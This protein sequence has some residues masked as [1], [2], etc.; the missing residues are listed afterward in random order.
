MAS[1][2]SILNPINWLCL[3]AFLIPMG[4]VQKQFG[5]MFSGIKI[6]MIVIIFLA[7]AYK[8]IKDKIFKQSLLTKYILFFILSFIPSFIFAY[9]FSEFLP[10]FISVLGYWALSIVI[11]NFVK[12]EDE[13][14][15]IVYSF[16]FSILL[17]SV[18]GMIQY[19]TG[20]TIIDV[21][22]RDSLYKW[23]SP[24]GTEET[25]YRLLGT[26]KNPSAFASHFVVAL[27]IIF[28]LLIVANGNMKRTSILSFFFLSLVVLILTF[29]RGA[30]LSAVISLF[31]IS[32]YNIKKKRFLITA[33]V[34]FFISTVLLYKYWP[35]GINYYM[36]PTAKGDLSLQERIWAIK[37]TILMFL[38]NPFGVGMGNYV[39]KIV[40]YGN[41]DIMPPHNIFAGIACELGLQG[42]IT[43]I[44]VI[45]LSFKFAIYGI[46]N[47]KNKE[48]KGLLIGLFGSLIGFQILGMSHS[49][50][51]NVALWLI[52]ALINAGYEIVKR[53]ASEGVSVE[54]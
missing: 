48:F 32:L 43:Y 11:L 52:I 14:R 20:S 26:E 15:K 38:N 28:S 5:L 39:N 36:F 18:F 3:L 16:L 10:V 25:R 46:K 51:I 37:P 4:E 23:D 22:G 24:T 41:P 54:K 6:V 31:I 21:S 45:A 42:L 33:A 17:V 29:S 7:V 12:H 30:I 40:E 1:N 27:P 19:K 47:A 9:N 13:L 2:K 8:I 34:L 53:Q 44:M 35:S 49:N 50:Y